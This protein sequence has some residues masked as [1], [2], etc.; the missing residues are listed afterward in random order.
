MIFRALCS[1]QDRRGQLLSNVGKRRDRLLC[2]VWNLHATWQAIS[3]LHRPVL[4][5]DEHKG[6]K[7]RPQNLRSAPFSAFL[8]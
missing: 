8:I 5:W 7:F 6:C 2:A 3:S 4:T 1:F